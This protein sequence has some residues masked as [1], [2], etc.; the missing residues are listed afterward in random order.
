WRL[1]DSLTAVAA[2]GDRAYQELNG[3]LIIAAVL[4]RAGLADSARHLAARSTANAE[5]DP[6]RDLTHIAAFVY[7]LLGD[8]DAAVEQLK[9]YLAVNP[10]RRSAFAEDAGWWFRSLENDPGFRQLV[11]DA[12]P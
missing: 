9:V 10:N 1:H 7:A 8:R 2:E 3:R 11:G 12:R 4:A 6:T 5:L